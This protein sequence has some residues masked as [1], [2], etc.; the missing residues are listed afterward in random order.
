MRVLVAV[1]GGIAAYKA[2]EVVR[3]LQ[4]HGVEVEVAMT[5]GAEEFVRPL[6][7]ASLTGRP[8]L[9]SLWE[10]VA[11]PTGKEPIEHIAVALRVDAVVV[12]PATAST[13]A[14]MAW[15]AGG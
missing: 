12:C 5:A 14:K 11:E 2:I 8:V 4:G 10:P 15:G 3:G 13:L 9:R 7:F 6:L 1:C